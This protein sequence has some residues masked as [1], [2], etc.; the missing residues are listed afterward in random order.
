MPEGMLVAFL[1][2]AG[3]IDIPSANCRFQV[4]EILP[5]SS[6]YSQLL[7]F[8]RRLD[9]TLMRK[10]M[11]MHEL[12]RRPPQVKIKRYVTAGHCQSVASMF[13]RLS[14]LPCHDFGSAK[15]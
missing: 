12:M 5:E 13:A 11:D 14:M 8:E 10:R 4:K 15:E 7:D 1:V 2:C 3:V 9:A 6:M